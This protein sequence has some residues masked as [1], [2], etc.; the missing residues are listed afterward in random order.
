MV[1]PTDADAPPAATP[2]RPSTGTA[3][4]SQAAPA[5]VV[6]AVV[7]LALTALSGAETYAR[8]GLPDPGAVVTYGLPVVRALTESAAV[9]TVGALLLAA[10]LVPPPG[11][12]WLSAEGYRAVR[13]ASW[14]A[15]AWAAGALVTGV[16]A[17]ADAFARPLADVL[18]TSTLGESVTGLPTA[19]IW[20]LTAGAAL[21]VAVLGRLALSWGATVGAFALA[22]VGVL[23][24]AFG[25]HSGTGTSHDL[26]TSSLALH[27]VAAAC[28]VGG[29]VAVLAHAA[30][31]GAHL[32]TALGRFSTTAF[33]CWVVLALSGTV[34]ALLRVNP[35]DLTTST[36][37]L[38]LLG[39]VAGLVV[40]GVFGATHRTR[41]VPE[42]ADG[43]R[44]ALVR[45]GGVEVL[46][47]FATIGVAVALGRT[48]PPEMTD[49][50]PGRGEA[51]LGYAVDRPL[52]LPG[53]VT[54]A[55]PDL[56]LGSL[57]VVAALA[58][59][60]GVRRLRRRGAEW[61]VARTLVWLVG[62]VVL[63]VATS[64][65]LGRYAPAQ[66]S[67]LMI[68]QVLVMTVVGPC[69]VLGR[70]RRLLAL[71]RP[72]TS[73]GPPGPGA[74][75]A[76]LGRSRL[77]RLL[78]SPVGAVVVFVGTGWSLDVAGLVDVLVP[79]QAGRL[80]MTAGALGAGCLL[81]RVVTDGAVAVGTRVVVL[82]VTA[83][84]QAGLS[85]VVVSSS[86]VLGGEY[87]D[88]LGLAF[89]DRPADQ[90]L[91]GLGLGLGVVPLLALLLS[92]RTRSDV[93]VSA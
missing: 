78:S 5:A 84:A 88:R 56:I 26:A 54:A 69:W 48:P 42:V 39:K 15:A 79:G 7:A 47:M 61:P 36:Y 21:A 22:V 10:F 25:G 81:A 6:A 66:V 60:A 18:T 90:V 77:G 72:E 43:S 63:L 68:Q 19:R 29:L 67:A 41:T 8:L 4:V 1:R 71:V 85:A 20:F 3:L 45:L 92:A 74:W 76:G 73:G 51:L 33:W 55:R 23:P 62:C 59:L 35:A 91:G 46:I 14:S 50:P 2:R 82:V 83:V 31:G 30:V 11:L 65:G 44:A 93:Q 49:A 9:V 32:P 57:A 87:W 86:R 27:V 58:Y 37:G 53:L 64:S 89:V 34:N 70:P 24:A 28:W 13:V 17:V 40:L 80:V 38:L 52:D 75:V 12:G 16:L